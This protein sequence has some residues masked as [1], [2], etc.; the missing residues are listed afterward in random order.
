MDAAVQQITKNLIESR[1]ALKRSDAQ[2][3]ELDRMLAEVEAMRQTNPS[4]DTDH[5]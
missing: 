4:P 5:R 2:V 1:K 3:V